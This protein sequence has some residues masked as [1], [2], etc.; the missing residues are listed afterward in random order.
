[1]T[2][3]NIIYTNYTY[4]L[5]GFF[6]QKSK[7]CNFSRAFC[8]NCIIMSC[9]KNLE[10]WH[11]NRQESRTSRACD[12]FFYIPKRGAS[13]KSVGPPSIFFYCGFRVV[14]IK[15]LIFGVHFVTLLISTFYNFLNDNFS[16]IN[17][18]SQIQQRTV[19]CL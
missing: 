16:V 2:I 12:F 8:L 19:V 6:F 3:Q 17:N 4:Y 1:M 18:P 7:W 14:V 15:I 13:L 5:G 11:T 10:I 9:L